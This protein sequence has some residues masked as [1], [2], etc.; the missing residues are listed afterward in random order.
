MESVGVG[1]FRELVR[2]LCS[3]LNCLPL[4]FSEILYGEK[5]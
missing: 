3:A 1:S 5:F 4:D 2:L